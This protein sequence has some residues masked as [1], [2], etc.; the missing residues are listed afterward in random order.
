[1]KN[2]LTI[3]FLAVLALVI[4]LVTAMAAT[5]SAAVP[6]EAAPATFVA[7]PLTRIVDVPGIALSAAHPTAQVKVTG[8][9]GVPDTA[10]AIAGRLVPYL[11]GASGEQLVAWDLRK[12]APGDPTATG[13]NPTGSATGNAFESTLSPAGMLGVHLISGSGRFLLEMTG[14]F[15]KAPA[16][17]GPT[18]A[19]ANTVLSD[20]PE[21][22]DWANDD[23]GRSATVTLKSQV[24]ADKCGQS[25]QQCFF[26]VGMLNDTGSFT[27]VDGAATPNGT[28]GTV[29][30]G[31]TGQLTGVTRI[32]FYATSDQPDGS[33]VRTSATGADKGG[34]VTT[35]TWVEQFFGPDVQFASVRLVTYDFEYTRLCEHWTDKIN[36][37]DD[38]QSAADGNI[39]GSS[40]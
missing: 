16:P 23:F 32:E 6:G 1:M 27:T 29:T 15:T 4:G 10:T 8:A 38:G 11:T 3:A 28:G 33:L 12:G 36:P 14:Y 35:S 22:S 40:C 24:D 30:G 31:R 37:G 9:H 2:K 34:R 20:W 26:Y 19:T 21:S 5:S 18:S 39:T 17:A 7:T 25:A 13:T